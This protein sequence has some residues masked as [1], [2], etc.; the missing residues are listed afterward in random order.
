MLVVGF[1]TIEVDDTGCY[2]VQ[3]VKT[4]DKTQH[5][6]VVREL[7]FTKEAF[8]ECYNKWILNGDNPDNIK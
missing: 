8:M 4:W 3:E 2:K 5:K 7:M 1:P 6:T